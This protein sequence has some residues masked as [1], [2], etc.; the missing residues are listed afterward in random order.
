MNDNLIIYYC[1]CTYHVTCSF[2]KAVDQC[3]FFYKQGSLMRNSIKKF[4][5]LKSPLIDRH[6]FLLSV[7]PGFL[8]TLRMFTEF[9][10]LLLQ[11][12]L[13]TQDCENNYEFV[14]TLLNQENYN[15]EHLKSRHDYG[16]LL[17]DLLTKHKVM[18]IESL[19]EPSYLPRN[20][21]Y[22]HPAMF[23]MDAN[24]NHKELN[25]VLKKMRFTGVQL[26]GWFKRLYNMSSIFDTYMKKGAENLNMNTVLLDAKE[27]FLTKYFNTFLENIKNQDIILSGAANV[28]PETN[29]SPLSLMKEIGS[30]NHEPSV[31]DNTG[32]RMEDGVDLLFDLDMSFMDYTNKMKW[33][34][35]NTMEDGKGNDPLM[36]LFQSNNNDK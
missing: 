20:Y 31:T 8:I 10:R 14:N 3:Q 22:F 21:D 1:L 12:K 33:F 24:G 15:I 28:P 6:L 17:K 18:N 23:Q 7:N 4:D 29:E 25:S 34:V 11:T 19:T 2:L 13:I 26:Y 30:E 35:S 5:E 32:I 36:E 16:R 9:S 27:K